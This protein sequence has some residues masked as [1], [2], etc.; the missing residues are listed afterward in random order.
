MG[1]RYE[2]RVIYDFLGNKV[3]KRYKTIRKKNETNNEKTCNTKR[4]GKY[5]LYYNGGRW[6][7]TCKTKY[8][9][10][11]IICPE[12]K[13]KVRTRPRSSGNRRQDVPRID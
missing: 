10:T 9:S 3:D 13:R 12:C 11:I 8:D 7:R 5:G 6:C 2:T 4:K 1:S